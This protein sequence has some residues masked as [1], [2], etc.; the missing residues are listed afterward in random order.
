M[1]RSIVYM[2][3][4]AGMGWTC[5]LVDATKDEQDNELCT[6]ASYNGWLI[7]QGTWLSEE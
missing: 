3:A 7:H 5:S 4:G 1:T 6:L 2:A